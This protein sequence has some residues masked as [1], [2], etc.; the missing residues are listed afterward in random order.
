[1]AT[2]FLTVLGSVPWGTVI[3]RAPD[4]AEQAG[5]LVARLRG[6]T[7]AQLPAPSGKTEA[8][9]LKALIAA[10]NDLNLR[11]QDELAK[12]SEIV[13]VLSRDQEALVGQMHKL[14]RIAFTGVATGLLS[15]SGWIATALL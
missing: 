3:E 15:L 4:I 6:Q 7:P 2:T 11:L 12:A 5:R 13:L 14:R 8:D 1:M 9:E 10:Q